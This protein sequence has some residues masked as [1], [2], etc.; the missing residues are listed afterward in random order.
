MAAAEAEAEAEEEALRRGRRRPS[1][2]EP[3]GAGASAAD[4]AVFQPLDFGFGV[5]SLEPHPA[6]A[7]PRLIMRCRK[8]RPIDSGGITQLLRGV[9][10]VLARNAPFSVLLDLRGCALP[11]R[12][13]RALCSSWSRKAWPDLARAGRRCGAQRAG[14][15]ADGQHDAQREL[16]RSSRRASSPRSPTPSLRPRQVRARARLVDAAA[17]ASKGKGGGAA[18][19]RRSRRRRLCRCGEPQ[20]VQQQQ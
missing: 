13:H 4:A 5:L 11:S 8:G 2:V 20:P 12:A 1:G 7:V 14:D 10:E 15:A 17:K 19:R 16:A 18:R 9:D 6:L 3:A